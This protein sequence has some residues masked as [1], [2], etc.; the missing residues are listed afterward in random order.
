MLPLLMDST[1][2][3][4]WR[5][6]LR[7]VGAYLLV[8][9][10]VA[11]S[12]FGI[13]V[14]VP[15]YAA[16]PYNASNVL[17]QTGASGA[18]S[19][20]T[21]DANDGMNDQGLSLAD[22]GDTALDSTNHR[23]F[24][25]EG[26][27]NRV[28]VFN[29]DSGNELLDRTADAVL[30]QT[31]FVTSSQATT[32]N[33]L[34]TPNGILY[35][36]VGDR[37]F[38]SDSGNNRIMVFNVAAITDGENA[39]NVLGQTLFTTAT[40][41]TTQSE[42]SGSSYMAYDSATK[43]LFVSDSFN[44]RV[45]VF[46]VTAITNGENAVNVL[47]QTDFV[48]STASTT[49][50]TVDRATGLAFDSATN[51]LFVGDGQGDRVLVFDVD[52]AVLIANNTGTDGPNATK[53]LGQTNFTN[54]TDGQAQNRLRSPGGLG[55]DSSTSRLFVSDGGNNRVMVFNV[56]AIT[57]G[58][59]AV[60]VLCQ[61]TY[62]PDTAATTQGGCSGPGSSLY[63]AT[64]K[65][66]FVTDRSNNRIMV[67]NVDSTVLI[68]DSSG[69]DG[70]NAVDALGQVDED[71]DPYYTSSGANNTPSIRGLNG[72]KAVEID[73]I[74]HRLFVAD[75]EN[76]RVLV[77][78]LDSGNDLANR[79]ADYVLGQS[80]FKANTA[81]GGQSGFNTPIS[82]AYD[83]TNNR[84][85]VGDTLNRVLVFDVTAITNGE[86]AVNVLGHTQYDNSDTPGDQNGLNGNARALAYDATNNRLF[87]GNADARVLVFDVDP[88]VLIANNTGTDG[89][90]A[91]NLI[92]HT[93]Y[94]SSDT[95]GSQA[96]IATSYALA[97]DATNS[98]LFVGDLGNA[99]VLVF[100]VT[101]ITDGENAVN[102]LGHTLYDG[103]DTPSNQNGVPQ[104]SGIAFDSAQNRLF[105]SDLSNNRVMVFD[106]T[107]ITDGENAV[108][109][110][111]Q[112][113]FD[114]FGGASGQS[115]LSA[116]YG[117]AHDAATNRLYVSD[118]TNNRVLIFDFIRITTGDSLPAGTTG[119]SYS[120]A[121][122]TTNSQG[123]VTYSLASG[124]LPPGLSLGS[125]TGTPTTAG[126]Y[127]F[128]VR[129]TDA[130]GVIGSFVDDQS[131]TITIAAGS[132]GGGGGG[133]I[134]LA[135]GSPLSTPMSTP[136]PTPIPVS[137]PVATSSPLPTSVVSP[138]ELLAS[139]NLKEGDT[140]SAAQSDDPDVYI[141]NELGFKR[142]FLN[143]IIFSFYGHLG[144]FAKV[145]PVTPKA[146][147]SFITSGLF[148]N[149]ETNDSRV[150]GFVSTG[151]DTGELRWINTSGQQAVQDDPNFFS[152]VFCINNNEFNWY[153]KSSTTFTSVNQIPKYTR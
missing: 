25:A 130:N 23:L 85:F 118:S 125:I 134:G 110:L 150:Y 119:T 84:L 76:H 132:S 49:Q 144:G 122:S 30:G 91:V 124:T 145:K 111:G 41:A 127:T 26:N 88:A 153:A 105:V 143:P 27:N 22:G 32:Q 147:D 137:T 36:A 64:S 20:T 100:D 68:A 52:P 1:H 9:A 108:N 14:P 98:R 82:L 129:A 70:P 21:A 33:G 3:N 19:F 102:V 151:E 29:L 50:S 99:R 39:V 2:T 80:S 24:V 135:Q 152:K 13:R 83:A 69:T 74:N 57:D 59:N 120:Q 93:A 90:N 40:A 95:P 67:F 12:V 4:A 128:T 94:D 123:T 53:V 106:V 8:F 81:V 79:T 142:L 78:D 58:E 148:R 18:V 77:F 113:D 47:G 141:V 46:D 114:S 28:L 66:L 35:D 54:F 56:A 89:P 73:R 43:R 97:Y 7:L 101:S 146:R 86:N 104:P 16:S 51:R 140:I 48:T 10:L 121:I 139:F 45:L 112:S 109:V 103:S 42:L 133:S 37:L 149:C 55:F 11:S 60:N 34:S 92:G 17:G 44:N 5:S 138:L 87:V 72:P 96:A 15:A 115:G 107:S 116:T 75:S 136:T 117:L 6:H 131:Y 61:T 63:D 65:H 38:V 71:G 31:D 126:T 62:G